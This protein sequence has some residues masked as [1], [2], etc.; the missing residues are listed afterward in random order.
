MKLS[1]IGSPE[2]ILLCVAASRK[3]AALCFKA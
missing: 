1:E 3:S 2:L